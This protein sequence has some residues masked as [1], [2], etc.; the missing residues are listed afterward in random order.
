M[1]ALYTPNDLYDLEYAPTFDR[2]TRN[3]LDLEIDALDDDAPIKGHQI[4]YRPD[5]DPPDFE[6]SVITVTEPDGTRRFTIRA[7]RLVEHDEGTADAPI[8][9]PEGPINGK[10]VE[11]TD[12][13][14]ARDAIEQFVSDYPDII[15][16]PAIPFF[17]DDV[18]EVAI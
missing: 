4:T 10:V 12:P 11:T 3:T 2:F 1:S 14:K 6:V 18:T 5:V 15:S 8:L 17:G 16:D 13:D 7:E 9:I